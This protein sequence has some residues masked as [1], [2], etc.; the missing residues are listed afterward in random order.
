MLCVCTCIL[1]YSIVVRLALPGFIVACLL[2]PLITEQCEVMWYNHIL[3]PP[4]NPT[5]QTETTEDHHPLP[6]AARPRAQTPKHSA[7]RGAHENV[8]HTLTHTH[9]HTSAAS[10][11]TR[12]HTQQACRPAPNQGTHAPPAARHERARS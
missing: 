7:T 6:H 10:P 12:P 9:R 8:T 1:S 3:E 5:D 2:V 4:K 11:T